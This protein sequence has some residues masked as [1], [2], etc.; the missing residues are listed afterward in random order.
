MATTD[1]AWLQV[2]DAAKA[3]SVTPKALRRRIERGTVESEL[4]DDGVR[5]V[6]VE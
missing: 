6:R 3:A 1:G 2:G 5:L 4:R